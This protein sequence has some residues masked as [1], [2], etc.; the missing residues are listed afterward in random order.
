MACRFFHVANSVTVNEGVSVVLD[1]ST[2]ALTSDKDRFCFKLTTPIPTD[3]AALR[4]LLTVNGVSTVALWNKY[5]NP[6]TA[7]ELK[8]NQCYHGYYGATTPHVIVRS[9]PTQSRCNC[10]L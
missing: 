8:Q 4:V 2:P 3:A 7:N 6:V 5:G 1:F 9:I 10:G